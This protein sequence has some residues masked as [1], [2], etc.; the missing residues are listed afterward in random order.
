MTGAFN[1]K[2]LKTKLQE[3]IEWATNEQK[4]LSV[5]YM[6]IDNFKDINDKYDYQR[7]NDVLAQVGRL[8]LDDKRA[9]DTLFR[10]FTHGD[11]FIILAKNTPGKFARVA[12]E[13]KRK[14][15]IKGYGFQGGKDI[16]NLTISSGVTEFVVGKDDAKTLLKR[17]NDALIL[18]KEEKDRTFELYD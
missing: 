6:D 8:L 5:I 10:D 4:P 16:I 17:A 18:A 2:A 15:V 14:E 9:T 13:R 12:A 11:E 3:Y 1:G 7:G